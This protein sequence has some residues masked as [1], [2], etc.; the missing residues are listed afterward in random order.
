MTARKTKLLLGVLV[1][2]APAGAHGGGFVVRKGKNLSLDG[3]EFRFAG[4]NNY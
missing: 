2:A 1:P 3:R 4:T